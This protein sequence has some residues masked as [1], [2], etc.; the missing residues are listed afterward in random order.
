MNVLYAWISCT[1]ISPQLKY[2]YSKHSFRGNNAAD[3]SVFS[4]KFDIWAQN[5]TNPGLLQI[6]NYFSRFWRPKPYSSMDCASYI[7]PIWP[8]LEPNL[9]ALEKKKT[10]QSSLLE[11]GEIWVC[12]F[13]TTNDHKGTELSSKPFHYKG[14]EL[15]SK[16]FHYGATVSWCADKWRS[17]I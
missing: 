6:I 2:D 14:T 13:Q 7:A 11:F 12:P 1:K 9:T 10:L 5:R 3:M 17:L 16:P 4:L 15:S 8:T